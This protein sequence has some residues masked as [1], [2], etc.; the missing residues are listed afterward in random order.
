MYIRAK[1]LSKID[2]TKIGNKMRSKK[3]NYTNR[4]CRNHRSLNYTSNNNS[5]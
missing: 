5:A 2:G 1:E 3:R 4:P